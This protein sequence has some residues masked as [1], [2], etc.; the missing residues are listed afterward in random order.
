MT[1]RLGT[2]TLAA[3]A[4]A[5]LATA[6]SAADP[7][8]PPGF[9]LA[10]RV[11]QKKLKELSGLARS[12]AY[13]GIFWAHNDSGDG[14]RLFALRANGRVTVPASLRTE[15]PWKGTRVA[16]AKNEDWED[17]AIARGTLYVA[18]LGNNANDRRDLGVYLVKEPAPDAEEAQALR[19][20]PVV[21]PEQKSF[22]AERWEFDCEAVFFDAGKL[23][24]LTKNRSALPSHHAQGGS[25]LYRLASFDTTRPNVLQRISTHPEIRLATGA[26]LSPNGRRL[27]VLST[28]RIWIFERPVRGD[29]WFAGRPAT[30]D[31]PKRKQLQTEAIAWI[32]DATLLVG[33]EDRTLLRV[34]VAAAIR[35]P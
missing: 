5:L 25:H 11:D 32:D 2:R 18:D 20:V 33:S 26:D 19:F 21:Y 10:G 23:Y 9:T 27:A 34:A 12:T 7:A 17:V 6:A 4:L 35:R 24:L 22:P 30:I 28:T 16:G 14:P 15:K 3:L 1:A 31:V 13:P 8:L 29:D